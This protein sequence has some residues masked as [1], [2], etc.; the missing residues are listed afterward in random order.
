MLRKAKEYL[1]LPIKQ[2]MDEPDILPEDYELSSSK[3]YS[4]ACI[5]LHDEKEEHPHECRIVKKY[6]Q[7]SGYKVFISKLRYITRE[8]NQLPVIHAKKLILYI[9]CHGNDNSLNNKSPKK[10]LN[11]LRA[12][13]QHSDEFLLIL[14]ACHSGTLRKWFEQECDMLLCTTCNSKH[15]KSLTD[16]SNI[17]PECVLTNQIVNLLTGK[18]I[19]HPDMIEEMALH[20]K[21]ISKNKG[22]KQLDLKHFIGKLQSVRYLRDLDTTEL[23][24][25]C[26]R[27]KCEKIHIHVGK[28]PVS[29]ASTTGTARETRSRRSKERNRHAS[30]KVFSDKLS[31]WKLIPRYFIIRYE[32]GDQVVRTLQNRCCVGHSL[33]KQDVIITKVRDFVHGHDSLLDQLDIFDFK[34]RDAHSDKIVFHYD[35][36]TGPK[37]S[38]KCFTEEKIHPDGYCVLQRKT[39]RTPYY[40]DVIFP[41]KKSSPSTKYTS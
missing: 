3:T 23:F 28:P 18:W 27:K 38:S 12:L 8:R 13:R 22:K 33:S 16:C 32:I 24:L 17:D 9:T 36:E 10:Y 5:C 7:K 19:Y 25:P 15:T 29:G 31:E 4:H 35:N 39:K 41:L 20:S 30:P 1:T 21:Y 11:Y 6:L 14:C 40:C 26:E 2:C 34:I 37:W